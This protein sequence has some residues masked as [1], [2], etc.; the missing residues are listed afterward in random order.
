[1]ILSTFTEPPT[2]TRQFRTFRHL[3]NVSN[4]IPLASIPSSS[5]PLTTTN[6]L[7]TSIGFP[8]MD[9]LTNGIQLPLPHSFSH[10]LFPL[11]HFLLPPPLLLL[12]VCLVYGHEPGEAA[13][14]WYP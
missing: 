8:I 7:S 5:Q 6:A 4:P 1:M 12:P 9:F 14:I 2:T 10:S 3:G 11:F 13:A